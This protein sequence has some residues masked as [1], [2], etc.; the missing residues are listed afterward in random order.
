MRAMIPMEQ[1]KD[2]SASAVVEEQ[3]RNSPS[4]PYFLVS[5]VHLALTHLLVQAGCLHH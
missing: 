2:Q 1:S 5:S 4:L 3:V